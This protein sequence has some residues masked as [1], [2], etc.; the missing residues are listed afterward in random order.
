MTYFVAAAL[1]VAA[2]AATFWVVNRPQLVVIGAGLP[3]D[4]P[5]TGFSHSSFEGLLAAYVDSDGRVDYGRW[6]TND[7]DRRRLDAYLAAVAAYS[8]QNAPERFPNKSDQLAYW[9]NAYNA[10]VIWSV[11]DHWP[12]DSVTDVKAP[13]EVVKGLGFFWRQRFVF[14]GA[15]MSLY[16]LENDV[17]RETFRDPRIHFVL[18][19]ASESCPVARPE[20]PTGADLEPF[21]EQ[22]TIEFVSDPKNVRV[23]HAD[24]RIVLS[25]IFKWYEKDFVNE[26]R[27]QGRS[28]DRPLIDYL[29]SVAPTPL[30]DDLSDADDYAIEFAG[31]D[32]GLNASG[33]P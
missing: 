13:I 33:Q 19:C 24:R 11:L 32:W 3:G 12:L 14:G 20:L 6:H 16:A 22:A 17:I 5:D 9:L 23:D 26:L 8:P 18:N 30:S 1:L 7:G 2:I 10:C 15:P 27:R 31:Y 25:D 29:C 4:F 28:S 21:L